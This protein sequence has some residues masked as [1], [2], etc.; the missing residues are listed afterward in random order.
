MYFIVIYIC[1]SFVYLLCVSN[2]PYLLSISIYTKRESEIKLQTNLEENRWKRNQQKQKSNAKI[3]TITIATPKRHKK[4][5]NKNKDRR[6][7][8]ELGKETIWASE[9]AEKTSEVWLWRL[10]LIKDHVL[11]VTPPVSLSAR[12]PPLITRPSRS[13]LVPRRWYFIYLLIF[14]FYM[15]FLKVGE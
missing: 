15:I 10:C 13:S 4:I 2:Y 6:R 14:L 7:N 3:T 11:A 5:D 8:R 12:M 9:E 1:Q